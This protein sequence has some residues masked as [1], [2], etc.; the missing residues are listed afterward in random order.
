MHIKALRKSEVSVRFFIIQAHKMRSAP[1]S[2]DTGAIMK[3]LSV[4]K[5]EIKS[6]A[7]L[8]IFIVTIKYE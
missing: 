5:H 4:K 2:H 6:L 8:T 3:N 1:V 7:F